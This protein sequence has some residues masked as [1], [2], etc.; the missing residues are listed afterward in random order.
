V[1]TLGPRNINRAS[2]SLAGTNDQAYH[3]IFKLRL[4]KTNGLR[5]HSHFS[6]PPWTFFYISS[7][8]GIMYF[9]NLS[10]VTATLAMLHAAGAASLPQTDAAGLEK[11]SV[12]CYSGGRAWGDQKDEARSLAHQ[13]CDENVGAFRTFWPN[14]Q[15]KT[16][17]R[18]SNGWI[19]FRMKMADSNTHILYNADC[20]NLLIDIINNCPLGGADDSSPVWRPRCVSVQQH[21]YLL[22]YGYESSRNGCPLGPILAM[23]ATNRSEQARPGRSP[24]GDWPML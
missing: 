5:T 21:F 2:P 11:R 18:Y 13:W 17:S 12:S 24:G 6:S 4:Y 3:P 8:S 22:H 20:A 10:V 7:F 9:N 15:V 16:C 23:A 1:Q 14:E 19:M